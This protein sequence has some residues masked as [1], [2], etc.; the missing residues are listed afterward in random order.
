[1]VVSWGDEAKVKAAVNHMRY[2]VLG[3]IVLVAVIFIAPL[4]LN[5]FGLGQYG[6]YFS[7]A[8]I[9]STIQEISAHILWQST[10]SWVYNTTD[11]VVVPSDSW[12][13]DL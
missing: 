6:Q 13:T 11:T 4:F 5:L 7:P 1:M 12:F 8:V 3:I 2:A 9:L 10:T